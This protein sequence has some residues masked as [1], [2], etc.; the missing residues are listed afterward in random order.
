[1]CVLFS[2]FISF[3]LKI[4]LSGTIIMGHPNPGLKH[5]RHAQS[6]I[7]HLGRILP[8]LGRPKP[9]QAQKSQVQARPTARHPDTAPLR[10]RQPWSNLRLARGC[11]AEAFRSAGNLRL[12]R[13][14]LSRAPRRASARGKSPSRPR[15]PSA[16][17][18]GGPTTRRDGAHLLTN[19]SAAWGGSHKVSGGV[20]W[21]RPPCRTANVTGIPSACVRHCATIPGAVPVCGALCGLA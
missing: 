19:H 17:Q 8:K 14:S 2:L 6:K 3:F 12:I 13:G 5:P 21:R 10:P 18:G 15:P 11:S 20:S 4:Q 16:N 7:R 9:L 1:M